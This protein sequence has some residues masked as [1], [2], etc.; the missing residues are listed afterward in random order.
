V[1]AAAGLPGE[2]LPP[3][4]TLTVA[5]AAGNGA[6]TT[7]REPTTTITVAH[8]EGGGPLAGKQWHC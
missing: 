8:Q 2:S 7:R 4:E 3:R 6:A 5:S 1:R